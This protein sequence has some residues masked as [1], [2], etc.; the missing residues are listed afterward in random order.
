MRGRDKVTQANPF[1]WGDGYS[2][3]GS[4]GWA[5]KTAAVD[6]GVKPLRKSQDSLPELA[7]GVSARDSVIR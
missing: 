6:G 4:S 2:R 3:G 5:M 1:P 7:R